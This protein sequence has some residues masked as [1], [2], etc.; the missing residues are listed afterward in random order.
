MKRNYWMILLAITIAAV[1]ASCSKS[2]DSPKSPEPGNVYLTKDVLTET[3]HG[4][5]TT[6]YLYDPGK[7]LSTI[8]NADGKEEYSYNADNRL[9]KITYTGDE[10][11][12]FDRFEYRDGKLDFIVSGGSGSVND[13]L[14]FYYNSQ[15]Q[16]IKTKERSNNT[17]T[18]NYTVA[19]FTYY[20][21]GYLHSRSEKTYTISGKTKPNSI[22]YT[23]SIN[24]TWSTGGNLIRENR[25]TDRWNPGTA[26]EYETT[27]D[28]DSKTNFIK[29]AHL[30]AELLLVLSLDPDAEL[31]ANNCILRANK[32]ITTN[33]TETHVFNITYNDQGYP[34]TI[35]FLEGSRELTYEAY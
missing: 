13:T 21:N 22:Y 15:G 34:I 2:D 30:P 1:A 23:D 27:Y 10:N 4:V 5:T 33:I 18:G 17:S 8:G 35:L 16:I 11:S 6:L 14:F 25:L 3:G 7:R 20:A 28:Y 31:S 12:D 26:T 19:E 32:N 29:A 9:Y 24:Y